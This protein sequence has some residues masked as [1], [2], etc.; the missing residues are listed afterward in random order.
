VRV[1]RRKL[2]FYDAP[3]AVAEKEEEAE[4][5]AAAEEGEECAMAAENAENAAPQQQ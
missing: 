2:H 5:E 1:W 4:A 3:G